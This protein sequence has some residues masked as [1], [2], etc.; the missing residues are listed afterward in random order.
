MIRFFIL[1][2]IYVISCC[3]TNAQQKKEV[4]YAGTFFGTGSKGIYVFEFD[5]IK[6]KLTL[7]QTVP[8][9]ESPT[10]LEIHPSGKFLYAVNRGPVEEMQNSGSVSAYSIDGTTGKLTLLNQR[11]SYGNG[12]CYISIDKTGKWAFIANYQEGNFV[13]MSV[14]DDGL[15]GSSS[16]AR[17]HLGN[18]VNA[19]RQEKPHVHSAVVSPDNQYVFVSDLGTDKIHSYKLN[20]ADGSIADAG[21]PFVSVKPGCG[22]R[23]LA[24]HP[25]GKYAYSA[26]ELTSTVA[27]LD[28]DKTTG[29]L[30]IRAD[31]IPSLPA[32]F[33]GTNTAADIHVHPG[34]K[35]LYMSNRGHNS[36]AIYAIDN[37]GMIKLVGQQDTKGKIPRNFLVDLKGE[38]VWVANQDSNNIVTFRVNQNTGKFQFVSNMPNV[39]APVCL[40]MLALR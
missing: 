34:G 30:A 38:F 8:T 17:K 33:K 28:Y 27:V 11:P 31:S 37:T 32:E 21:V 26:E 12:P 18:S 15:L 16:G 2:T 3:N 39:P 36:L 40:K 4:L 6:G 24:L 10:Y 19:E 35:F 23:H 20:A 25:N 13:V 22:P 5:R 1:L 29:S 7:L 9:L 14:F